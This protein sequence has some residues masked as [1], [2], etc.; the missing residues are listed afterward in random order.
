MYTRQSPADF[1][2]QTDQRPGPSRISG[3]RGAGGLLQSRGFDTMPSL[4]D[5]SWVQM[6]DRIKGLP[7]VALGV[8]VVLGVVIYFVAFRS[9]PS[10]SPAADVPAPREAPAPAKPA[11]EPPAPSRS[12][13]DKIL[14]GA[15][16][17]YRSGM[18]PTALK[19]YKDFELRYAG[20]EVYDQNIAKVWE[21]IHTCG[22]KLE[23][24]DEELP[25]YLESR[26]KLAD[27]WKKIKPLT[28][29]EPTA[30]SRELA[31]K[32]AESLPPQ[33]GRRKILD[34]W[35]SPSRDEK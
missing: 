20:T 6:A 31:R 15:D 33:D 30:E 9:R 16:G 18:Y 4:A 1:A 22:A 8:L 25:A 27:E 32:F 29:T 2:F 21:R 14:E 17:A 34:A 28:A 23:K 26:R 7:L 11:F 3:I 24:K 10:G 12:P 5:L 13:G 19:F 35:L